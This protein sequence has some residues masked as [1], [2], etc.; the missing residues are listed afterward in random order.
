[1]KAIL[2]D[3][4]GTL[5]DSF[6]IIVGTMRRVFERAGLPIPSDEAVH[7]VIGLSLETAIHRLTPATDGERLAELTDLYRSTFH[8]MR[9]DP[10]MDETLFDGVRPMLARLKGRPGMV[11][12]MVTGKS[13]RGVRIIV[14]RHDLGAIFQVVRTADDCPSKPDPAMVLE[15][16]RETGVDPRDCVV[17][18]DSVYDMAMGVAAGA[19]AF[20]VSWGAAGAPALEAAGASRVFDD[21]GSLCGALEE[22][23]GEPRVADETEERVPR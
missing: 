10:A 12:G 6:G 18:G 20:G 21:V 15:C 11:L 7:G 13:R 1:M 23:I 19:T 5:A 4:D 17:V 9:N 14:E 3:C 16:C 22:W 2:F 8:E